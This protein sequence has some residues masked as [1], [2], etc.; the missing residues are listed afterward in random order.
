MSKLDEIQ[1]ATKHLLWCLQHADQIAIATPNMSLAEHIKFN[2][3]KIL[4]LSG[5]L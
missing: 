5:E 2:S 3:E 4:T 1:D